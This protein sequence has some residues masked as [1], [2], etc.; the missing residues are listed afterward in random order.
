MAVESKYPGEYSVT[1]L[2]QPSYQFDEKA[3]DYLDL[4]D[5]SVATERKY[6]I[7]A[8]F[9]KIFEVKGLLIPY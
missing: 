1:E 4:E 7:T 2:V 6:C 5:E 9:L 3:L 8:G